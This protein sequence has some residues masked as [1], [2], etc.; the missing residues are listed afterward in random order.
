M[1]GYLDYETDGQLD[2]QDMADQLE[3]RSLKIAD[4]RDAAYDKGYDE[5]DPK[6]SR[7]ECASFWFGNQPVLFRDFCD[8]W[9]NALA[10]V[11]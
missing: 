7:D 10:G 11:R 4:A 2:A 6:L 3:E 9:D 5:A 8:G 1:N